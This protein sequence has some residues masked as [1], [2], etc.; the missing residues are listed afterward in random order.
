MYFN[1]LVTL[2]ITAEVPRQIYQKTKVP[3]SRG[4]EGCEE[5]E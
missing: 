3:R 5:Q 2:S 4:K 1:Y